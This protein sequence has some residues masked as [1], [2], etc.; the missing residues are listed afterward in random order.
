MDFSHNNLD[1]TPDNLQ[2]AKALLVLNVAHNRYFIYLFLC[3]VE[4]AKCTELLGTIY[5][6]V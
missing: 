4:T 6:S 1:T 2:R 5:Y 3:S